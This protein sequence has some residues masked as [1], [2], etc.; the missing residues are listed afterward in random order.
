[1][2]TKA[3]FGKEMAPFLQK[4]SKVYRHPSSSMRNRRWTEDTKE[5]NTRIWQTVQ[6]CHSFVW[7]FHLSYNW[8]LF[9][10]QKCIVA[11]IFNFFFLIWQRYPDDDRNCFGLNSVFNKRRESPWGLKSNWLFWS[12]PVEQGSHWLWWKPV[13]RTEKPSWGLDCDAPALPETLVKVPDPLR[14]NTK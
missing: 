11:Q 4:A 14:K 7:A 10:G 1:M 12:K 9:S 2:T 5:R 13:F 8:L 3:Q 6:L